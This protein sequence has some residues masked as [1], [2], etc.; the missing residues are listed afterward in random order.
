MRAQYQNTHRDYYHSVFFKRYIYLSELCNRD[1]TLLFFLQFYRS[2]LQFRYFRLGWL[3][4]LGLFSESFTIVLSFWLHMYSWCGKLEGRAPVNW[5][6]IPVGWLQLL[7][8]NV[9]I[10]S[11][12]NRRVIECF[13]GVLCCHFAFL[14]FYLYM[15]LYHG[16][17]SDLFLFL[18]MTTVISL[19]DTLYFKRLGMRVV[20]TFMFCLTL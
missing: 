4:V 3:L 14:N 18:F 20:P 12:C 7:K 10:K 11:V 16:N 17:E 15:G 5:L 13:G 9:L 8:A 19:V 2:D 6:T 1:L